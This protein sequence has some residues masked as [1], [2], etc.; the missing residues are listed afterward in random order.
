MKNMQL[1]ERNVSINN[2]SSSISQREHT[3]H[4][5]KTSDDLTTAKR[6]DDKVPYSNAGKNLIL[7]QKPSSIA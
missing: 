1:N 5:H 2:Y 7:N 3:Y 4:K 6:E